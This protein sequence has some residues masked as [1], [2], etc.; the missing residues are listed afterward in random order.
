[1]KMLKAVSNRTRPSSRDTIM[2]ESHKERCM[3][4]YV[5]NSYQT[6]KSLTG[7]PTTIKQ[8]TPRYVLLIK[9]N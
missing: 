6:Q 5:M 3:R 2:E 7:K 8:L 9:V 1:M 4:L